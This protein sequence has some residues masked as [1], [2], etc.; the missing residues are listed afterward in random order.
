ML[1]RLESVVMQ[2]ELTEI[3][4]AILTI[5]VS[6]AAL[7]HLLKFKIFTTGLRVRSATG[8]WMRE[9]EPVLMTQVVTEIP[10]PSPAPALTGLQANLEAAIPSTI[11]LTA[12]A[13]FPVGFTSEVRVIASSLTFSTNKVL[14]MAGT[15]AT[16]SRGITP[17]LS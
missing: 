17:G 10:Q 14:G 6:I 3:S 13:Q 5:F 11:S 4:T 2:V 8:N 16:L 1:T 7:S 9:R 12:A 15:L